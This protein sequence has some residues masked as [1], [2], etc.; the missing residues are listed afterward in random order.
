MTFASKWVDPEPKKPKKS[1]VTKPE[2]IGTIRNEK[3]QFL[4]GVCGNTNRVPPAPVSIVAALKRR[5]AEVNPENQKTYLE[6]MIDVIIEKGTKTK[7]VTMMR[8]IVNRVDGLPK[9]KIEID[10]DVISQKV[11]ASEEVIA[12]VKEFIEWRKKNE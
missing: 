1:I 9:Q 5:L 8:D 4:P 11:E 2:E 10:A 6:T 7:D 3:G 12:K